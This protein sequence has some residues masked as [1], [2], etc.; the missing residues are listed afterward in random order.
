MIFLYFRDELL[1]DWAGR[2]P[3]MNIDQ[4]KERIDQITEKYTLRRSYLWLGA[5]IALRIALCKLYN[6]PSKFRTVN[7]TEDEIRQ[8]E[9]VNS[10]IVTE[11][12]DEDIMYDAMYGR[13]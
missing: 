1:S 10:K 9:G 3:I 8:L 5:K 2:D 13:W 12:N 6:E 7:V 4:L 11:E